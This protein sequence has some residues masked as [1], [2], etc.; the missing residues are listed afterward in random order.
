M[1]IFR[2]SDPRVHSLDLL[3]NNHV[4]QKK[5]SN[6]SEKNRK[7]T[8]FFVKKESQSTNMDDYHAVWMIIV[9]NG[10]L[11]YLHTVNWEFDNFFLEIHKPY[12]I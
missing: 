9:Q 11:I 4:H 5:N 1:A 10:S 6:F 7:Q 8:K 3:I 12:F 2:I